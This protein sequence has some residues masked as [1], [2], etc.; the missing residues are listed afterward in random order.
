MAENDCERLIS[1]AE[2]GPEADPELA[3]I[4]AAWKTLSGTVKRMILAVLD[5]GQDQSK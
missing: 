4:V 2:T 5:A 1:A 3:R